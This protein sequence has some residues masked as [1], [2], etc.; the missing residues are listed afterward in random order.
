MKVSKLG[1]RRPSAVLKE[2][3]QKMEE[4]LVELRGFLT[5]EKENRSL[6]T[7][8]GAGRR[9]N[10]TTYVDLVRSYQP[11]QS[12]PAPAA[13]IPQTREDCPAVHEFLASCGLE[14]Y[15]N[16]FVDNGFEDLASMLELTESHLVTLKIPLGHRLKLLR[17]LKDT[18][19]AQQLEEAA[20]ELAEPAEALESAELAEAVE[21]T[22]SVARAQA[23]PRFEDEWEELQPPTNST[24][25]QQT[26]EPFLAPPAE[27]VV[28]ADFSVG[29]ATVQ[30][31]VSCW[32]CF[33][34]FVKERVF[35]HKDFCSERCLHRYRQERSTFCPCG[36]LLLRGN[37]RFARGHWHCSEQCLQEYQETS[38][39]C[40]DPATGDPVASSQS[41]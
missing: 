37:G 33:T 14:R 23:A 30:T 3:S 6:R 19:A 41:K 18:L 5:K 39:P 40:I 36:R 38:W 20:L 26:S 13:P 34:L 28:Y 17:K 1:K 10:E 9:R 15:L 16:L 22:G 7:K 4:R 11:K 27:P 8:E 12:R 25:T 35:D 24:I 31:K 32:T 21:L 29:E 2:E